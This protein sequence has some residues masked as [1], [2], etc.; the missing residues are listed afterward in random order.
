M[1]RILIA[2]AVLVALLVGWVLIKD[3]VYLAS[4]GKAD[5]VPDAPDYSYSENWLERPIQKPPGAWE[6]PWGVD[7]LL[8]APPAT[9]KAPIGRLA[10]NAPSLAED[11]DRFREETE[12]GS[13]ALTIYAPG[14]RS[15]S[16]ASSK[17]RWLEGMQGAAEDIGAAVGRYISTD[18][19][20][21]GLIIVAAP[22]TAPLLVSALDALPSDEAF[23]TRFGGVFVPAG[24]PIEDWTEKVG[25]CSP[26]V[27]TCVVRTSIDAVEPA[28]RFIMPS[29]P[30]SR[31]A[32]SADDSLQDTLKGRA[33]KL[34]RWLDDNAA[35]PAEP[36]NSW[37][38]DEIVD[39]EPIRR[40]NSDEDISGER[41]N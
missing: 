34:A 9:T 28:R 21:R 32:Y 37:S 14:Y 3:S 20:Q 27:E 40:P 31:L 33:D 24:Q 22:D 35:K 2:L 12:I 4:L 39:V 29:L 11:Y 19:R 5:A 10:A 23:R 6:T 18:N 8:I 13:D 25:S 38:A 41:G 36:F 7:I 16:P 1:R 30:R 26:A 15:P 17:A